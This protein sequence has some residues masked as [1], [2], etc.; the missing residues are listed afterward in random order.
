M[1]MY[2]VLLVDDEPQILRGMEVGYTMGK[3]W[4]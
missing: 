1:K 3:F 2:K 4:F